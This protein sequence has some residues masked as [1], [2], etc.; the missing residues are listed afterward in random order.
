M[1]T[2]FYG[3]RQEQ[4]EA[5]GFLETAIQNWLNLALLTVMVM[6]SAWAIHQSRWAPG[7]E[8]VFW[9]TGLGL[10]AGYLAAHSRLSTRAGWVLGAAAGFAY[11]YL[12]VGEVVPAPQRLLQDTFALVLNTLTWILAAFVSL[13]G[14]KELPQPIPPVEAVSTFFNNFVFFANRLIDWQRAVVTG[15]YSNDNGVFVFWIT[16]V[17]WSMGY[18][19]TWGFFRHSDLTVA[20]LVPGIALVV[21]LA[22]SGQGRL[23][24]IIFLVATLLLLVR[25]NMRTLQQRWE[26]L[27]LDYATE[28]GLDMLLASIVLT[29]VLTVF[30][31]AAPRIGSNPISEGFWTFFGQRWVELDNMSKRLFSG[32]HNPTGGGALLGQDNRLFS[33]PSRLMQ[34]FTMYVTTDESNFNGYWRGAAFDAYTGYTW[35]NTDTVLQDRRVGEAPAPPANVSY[36]RPAVF[37][38]QVI[39]YASDVLFVPDFPTKISIPYRVQVAGPD[40]TGDYSMLRARRIAVPDLEYT[41][42]ALVTTVTEDQLVS[43]PK[44]D[45]RQLQRYL[46]LPKVPQR[47]A[48]LTKTVTRGRNSNYEKALAI[49]LFLRR[50]PYSLSV[51][52]PPSDRDAV[53]YFLFEAQRGYADYYAS[54]M[55]TMLR[56]EGIPARLAV[57]FT[58]GRYDGAKRRFIVTER[59]AHTWPEVY[60]PDI[61]WI[62]FEPSPNRDPIDRGVLSAQIEGAADPALEEFY[63]GLPEEEFLAGGDGSGAAFGIGG[64]SIELF[65]VRLPRLIDMWP[66]AAAIMLALLLWSIIGNIRERTMSPHQA[67]RHIYRKLVRAGRLAGIPA[68]PAVTPEEYGTLVVQQAARLDGASFPADAVRTIC[69]SYTESLYSTHG[70]S[71]HQKDTVLGAWGKLR[72]KLYFMGAR[73]RLPLVNGTGSTARAHTGTNS[74]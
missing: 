40:R 36:R 51:P 18:L 19:G 12:V 25:L 58:T 29:A 66:V 64:G 53:D 5:P 72:W 21:N 8:V 60:F 17:G 67:V 26:A 61:G 7:T 68:H 27:K 2:T 30:A 65:G 20:A 56:L 11:C 55:V 42:E 43:A 62:P 73:Q 52:P 38:F 1:S 54:A 35:Y 15:S 63:S 16:V 57:G 31:V 71:P 70:L 10:I 6:V 28:V 45:T 46:Q 14:G 44:P 41:V 33:G 9:V 37:K 24:F 59:E 47:V 39:D 32:L 3:I 34:P 13:L 50:I 23:P 74:R 22:Y 4:E 69:R 49:E 48:D